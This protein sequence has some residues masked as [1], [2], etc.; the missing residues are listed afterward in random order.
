MLKPSGAVEPPGEKNKDL[1]KTNG[2]NCL[3]TW[4]HCSL[5][6]SLRRVFSNNARVSQGT[7]NS[8]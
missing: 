1:G 5:I 3:R 7:R 4:L 2:F 6:L 8:N